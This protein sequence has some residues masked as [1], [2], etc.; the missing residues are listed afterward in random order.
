MAFQISSVKTR[1]FD[2]EDPTT[3]GILHIEPPK[4][5]TMNEFE[6]LNNQNS[7]EDLAAVV[8]KMLSKNKEGRD[9]TADDVMNW[10]DSD[11]I[12]VFINAFLC[13]VNGVKA[14]DPN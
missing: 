5:K 2:F 12:S 11:Q 3:D 9:V 10:M 4:L 6:K 1:Y 7:P 13:W 8:A 14:N